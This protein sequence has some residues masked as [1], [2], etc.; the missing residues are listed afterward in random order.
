MHHIFQGTSLSNGENRKDFFL[1]SLIAGVSIKTI[2][3][4]VSGM[5]HI[6]AFSEEH[7]DFNS[8][9]V[10]LLL[11]IVSRDNWIRNYAIIQKNT[12]VGLFISF[13]EYEKLG[14][15][16]LKTHSQ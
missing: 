7:C 11:L 14:C 3:A 9:H 4:N 1:I 10:V 13:S 6:K 5:P 16:E 15:A 2:N 8:E 12:M